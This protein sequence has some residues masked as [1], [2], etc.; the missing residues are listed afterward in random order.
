MKHLLYSHQGGA[1][2]LPAGEQHAAYSCYAW[3]QDFYYG[4]QGN[5]F[6]SAELR[7]RAVRSIAIEQFSIGMLKCGLLHMGWQ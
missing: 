2:A 3:F 7:A 1:E 5:D 4:D 6:K